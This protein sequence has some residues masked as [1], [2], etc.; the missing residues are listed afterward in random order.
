M[1]L[2]TSGAKLTFLLVLVPVMLRREDTSE[3]FK[4]RWIPLLLIVVGEATVK[5]NALAVEKMVPLVGVMLLSV[6][7]PTTAGISMKKFMLSPPLTNDTL[8]VCWLPSNVNGKRL[9]LVSTKG[10]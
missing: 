9:S 3:P 1:V 8:R 4:L 2:G 5:L 6:G 7:W 10:T